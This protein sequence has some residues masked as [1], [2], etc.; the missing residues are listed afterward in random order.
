MTEFTPD[1]CAAEF[2]DHCEMY[3]EVYADLVDSWDHVLAKPRGEAETAAH[4]MIMVSE[5]EKSDV[6][7]AVAP[8]IISQAFEE[9]MEK[10]T[11]EMSE[12]V[13]ECVN[14]TVGDDE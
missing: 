2:R 9:S 1:D 12:E 7:T 8:D 6:D 4:M 13:W 10:A 3:D 14:E 11:E 5:V